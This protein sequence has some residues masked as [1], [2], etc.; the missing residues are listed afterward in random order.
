[1]S[2]LM[3]MA[4]PILPGKFDQWRQFTDKLNKEYKNEFVASRKSVNLHER[5]FLQRT[6]DMDFVIVTLEGDDPMGGF[7]KLYSR[8]DA[9]TKWFLKEV[10]AVHGTDLTKPLPGPMPELIVDTQA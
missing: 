8:D 5:T 7:Q 2:K 10:I 9:F 6:P 1:M 3:A 4:I